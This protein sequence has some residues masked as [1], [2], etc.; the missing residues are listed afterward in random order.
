MKINLN[1]TN[2]LRG[3]KVI[4]AVQRIPVLAGENTFVSFLILLIIAIL[5]AT[6]V[7]YQYALLANSA[8][9][10]LQSSQTAFQEQQFSKVLEGLDTRAAKFREIDFKQ[11]PNI[12]LTPT[13]TITTATATGLT[14]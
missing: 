6:I 1:F 3:K 5:I 14:E 8:P 12:F 11:Y 2:S 7:F 13:T 4:H 10:Q 9:A